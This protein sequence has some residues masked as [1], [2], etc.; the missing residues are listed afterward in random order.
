MG[1]EKKGYKKLIV[2]QKSRE[3]ILLVYKLTKRF[4]SDEKFVLVPQMR[5]SALSVTANIAEGY[6]KN[7]RKDF[8]RFVNISIGSITELEFFLEISHELNYITG[9][10]CNQAISLILEV[11]KLLYSSQKS[12]RGKT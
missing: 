1:N 2:Y 12:L 7:F 3:L 6:A 4:P 11:K 8:A 10:E 5:R 9:T